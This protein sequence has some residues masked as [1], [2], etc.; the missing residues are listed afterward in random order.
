MIYMSKKLPVWNA[1][2]QDLLET[3]PQSLL[4]LC[5]FICMCCLFVCVVRFVPDNL[6]SASVV[7]LLIK[8]GNTEVGNYY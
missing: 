2:Q 5:L 7:P 1:H 8:N 3:V 4:V 6:K